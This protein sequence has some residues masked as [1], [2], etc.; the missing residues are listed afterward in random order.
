MNSESKPEPG[1]KTDL[2]IDQAPPADLTQV[3]EAELIEED[4]EPLGAN[5]A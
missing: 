3:D 1:E 2:L 5:F 4:G